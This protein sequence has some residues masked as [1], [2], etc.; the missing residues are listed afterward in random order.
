MFI[1]SLALVFLFSKIAFASVMIDLNAIA[2]NESKF[3]KYPIN[4]SQKQWSMLTQHQIDQLPKD[5][6]D[7]LVQT[8]NSLGMYQ[9]SKIT[10]Q[11]WNNFHPSQKFEWSELLDDDVNKTIASW[12]LE[13][14][15]P[16]MLK[17]YKKEDTIENRLTAYNCGISCVLQNRR[18]AITQKYITDYNNHKRF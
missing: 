8:A 13:K 2:G 11:E 18:P 3:G 15:I 1:I 9:I 7:K 12:Y 16:Q 14:R 6:F 4:S 10:L 5:D 17:H